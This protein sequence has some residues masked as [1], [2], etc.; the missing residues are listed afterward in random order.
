MNLEDKKRYFNKIN[1]IEY[2]IFINL[3][4]IVIKINVAVKAYLF[5]ILKSNFI[6]LV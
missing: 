5:A 4:K 3:K 2:I 1:D 6:L